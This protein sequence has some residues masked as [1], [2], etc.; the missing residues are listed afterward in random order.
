MLII[1]ESR[2]DCIL[3]REYKQVGKDHGMSFEEF[4]KYNKTYYCR[5][6][7]NQDCYAKK[8]LKS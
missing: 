7:S 5:E 3:D 2:D 4:T 8:E 6:C 1:M